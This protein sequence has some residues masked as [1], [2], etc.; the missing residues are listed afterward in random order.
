MLQKLSV[1]HV[2]NDGDIT[3]MYIYVCM[4]LLAV[5]QQPKFLW[6]NYNCWLLEGC[7]CDHRVG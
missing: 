4:C 3:Y 5:A 6:S 1:A 2:V 7:T